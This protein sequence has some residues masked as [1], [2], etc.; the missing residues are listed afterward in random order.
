MKLCTFSKTGEN[1]RATLR[2]VLLCF[3]VC[4]CLFVNTIPNEKNGGMAVKY[5]NEVCFREKEFEF[6]H[7]IL[8]RI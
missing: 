4:H 7:A 6:R 2:C 5:E 1:S 8:V 3:E